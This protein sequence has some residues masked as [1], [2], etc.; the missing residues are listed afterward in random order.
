MKQSNFKSVRKIKLCFHL[1]L[2]AVVMVCMFS[3]NNDSDE[4]YYIRMGVTETD[5]LTG[6]KK[7][8]LIERDYVWDNSKSGDIKSFFLYSNLPEWEVRTEAESD[9]DWIEVWPGEGNEDGRFYV[10][11]YSNSTSEE[12][13]SSL[14]IIY[15]G[16][17]YWTIPVI[18][19]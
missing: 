11:V 6:E 8:V 19:H 13:T 5:V 17:V 3:C 4:Q 16:E 2:I 9:V 12:R 14:N 15:G 1:V 18:Q 10:K 7:D